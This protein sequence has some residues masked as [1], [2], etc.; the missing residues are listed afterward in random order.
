MNY[1]LFLPYLSLL[2][3]SLL[4]FSCDNENTNLIESP[5]NLPIVRGL[6]VTPNLVD[7]DTIPWSGQRT[8]D[9]ELTLH[10]NLSANAADVDGIGDIKSV[11]YQILKP[12]S[13]AIIVQ[14]ELS[15]EPFPVPFSSAIPEAYYTADVSFKIKRVNVGNYTVEVYAVDKSNLTSNSD[16]HAVTV[17]RYSSDPVISDLA[18]PDTITLPPEPYSVVFFISLAV[19][20]S[21]GIGDIAEVYFRNLD[22]PSDTNRK[23]GLYD[24]GLQN[25]EKYDTT[26]G[27]GIYMNRFQM[28]WNTLARTYRFEFVARDQLANISNKI[29]HYVV[30]RQP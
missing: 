2:A 14:G 29:L 23:F 18:A 21:D 22:S 24:D 9:D 25:D 6:T 26:A 30:V 28:P 1:R 12:A 27:D 11:R 13:R 4:L 3:L 5:I 8:P 19:S 7:T 10:V 16:I 20:D 15:L 17:T